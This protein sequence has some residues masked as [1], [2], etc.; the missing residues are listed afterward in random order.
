MV[1]D[2]DALIVRSMTKVD[3]ALLSGGERLK[4]VGRAGIGVDN[5]DV[6]TATKRGILVVNAPT[7]NLISATEH[8]FAL[9]LGLVR[10]ITKA[11]QSVRSGE[12]NRKRFLG[13]ELQGKCL[14][15]VGLGRIGRSVA[16]RAKAFD[17][18]IIAFDPYLD[19]AVAQ[20]MGIE[21]TPL[22]ELMGR[23]DIVTLHTPLTDQTR[24][25]VSRDQIARMKPGAFLIN[26]GRGGLVDEAAL[27]E[28]LEKDILGGAGLDVFAE[29][30]P[31]DLGLVRHPRVVATP[32]IGAQTK[33]AQERVATETVRMVLSALSGSLAVTAVNLPFGDV[34]SQ[35]Q[36][37]LSLG[38]QLGKL[39]SLVLGS[40]I[41]EVRVDLWGIEES[42]RTPAELAA[43]KGVLAA[44]LGEAVS[45]VNAQQMAEERGID[46]VISTLQR[47]QDYSH[48]LGVE[49]GSTDRRVS[50]AGTLFGEQD[51]R[52]VRFEDYQLE[53]RP[54][55]RLLVVKN[56]DV[57]GVVGKVG[58]ILGDAS[59]NIAEINL[60]RNRSDSGSPSS[61]GSTGSGSSAAVLRLDQAP[62][63]EVVERI[64]ALPEVF[65]AQSLDLGS[66]ESSDEVPKQAA[67]R[68]DVEGSN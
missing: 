52:V 3:A 68:G 18:Q 32:H 21:I 16:I 41:L 46:V 30:P 44:F 6:E 29:E 67:T 10:N 62:N 26:C 54:T 1:G 9:M 42:L 33:E 37:Y 39:A 28:A 45:F 65:S 19:P 15:I 60:A 38:E 5:V 47:T 51:P 8:T 64:R 25:L 14:G 17:M 66:L 56:A 48:L 11:D 50:V 59:V 31:R 53:F 58:S 57:P 49:I 7:A 43:L 55:G 34:G 40:S 35:G 2:F 63:Q 13:R 36:V 12:W 61:P 24:N 20:K 23:A 4:V 22:D 27:L